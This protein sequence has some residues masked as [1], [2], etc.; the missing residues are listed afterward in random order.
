MKTWNLNCQFADDCIGSVRNPNAFG[1]SPIFTAAPFR[2]FTQYVLS[3]APEHAEAPWDQTQ[4]NDSVVR[5][6]D[7][8]D[9]QCFIHTPRLPDLGNGTVA[10][11]LDHLS[12]FT[13][14]N[15]SG[16]A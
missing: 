11:D 10:Q 16:R 6:D 1:A 4:D 12:P 15:V 8:H 5:T 9:L 2:Y 14:R 13:H 7:L 3:I